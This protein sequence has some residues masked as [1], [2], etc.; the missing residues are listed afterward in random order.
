MLTDEPY[1]FDR[2]NKDVKKI[3]KKQGNKTCRD[4]IYDKTLSCAIAKFDF[5][6]AI[7]K[8]KASICNKKDD[9]NNKYL[10][11]S[12]ILFKIAY[13]NN[14]PHIFIDLIC[15]NINYEN[16]NHK[17]KLLNLCCNYAKENK[18]EFI[19]LYAINE[20]KLVEWYM[21]NGFTIVAPINDNN[22]KIKVYLMRKNIC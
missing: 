20:H 6:Y 2:K 3:L 13:I 8:N 21:K 19:Q 16:E 5:G 10:L 22:G 4:I 15:S 7:L 9:T 11:V 1:F 18:I 14:N 12:F 17:L